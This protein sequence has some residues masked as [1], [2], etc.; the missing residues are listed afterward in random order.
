MAQGESQGTGRESVREPRLAD[1]DMRP[2][3]VDDVPAIVAT[4]EAGRALLAADGIDQWQD[5]AGPDVDLV[6]SDVARGWGRVFLIGGQVAATAALIDEP[7][8]AYD[9]VVEGAWQVRGDAAPAG[10]ASPYATIHRVAVAPAFRGMHVAQRFYAR[11]IEEARARGFAEIRVDTHADN[12]RMQHVIASAGFTR[13]CTVLI[14]NN[15]KDL[16]WAYQL[17][18]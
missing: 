10:A 17:F 15:P 14:G 5:G 6:T 3:T 4:L 9:Q 16:R 11:L 12:V 1:C 8:P 18:L 2:A 13:A 7:E